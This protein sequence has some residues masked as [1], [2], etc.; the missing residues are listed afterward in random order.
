MDRM[1]DAADNLRRH[2]LYWSGFFM[3]GLPTETA[4]DIDMTI[5]L[6]R[7]LKPNYATFSIFTPY[8][9]T[10]LYDVL[11]RQGLVS[12]K[13]EWHFYNH[14]SRNNNFTGVMRDE[15]FGKIVDYAL[16]VFDSYNNRLGNILMRGLS[17]TT[18]YIHN[19][20]EFL[21]DIKR[22]INY[23]GIFQERN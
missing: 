13:I 21:R 17:R 5:A 2:R 10:E 23:A 16:K 6:M 8:P 22:Y 4:E 20:V 9:G 1:Q 3:I 7:R 11:L 18:V 19:P 12:Q 14:Q 15:E